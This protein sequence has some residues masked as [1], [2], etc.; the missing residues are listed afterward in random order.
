[1]H[2]HAE[3]GNEDTGDFHPEYALRGK[4][5]NGAERRSCMERRSA[6]RVAALIKIIHNNDW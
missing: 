3:R 6:S 1:M 4:R 2:S 5:S